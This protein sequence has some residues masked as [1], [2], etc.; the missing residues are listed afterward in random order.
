MGLGDRRVQRSA[1]PDWDA[2]RV[3]PQSVH[4]TSL[5]FFTRLWG[6]SAKFSRQP[7][8]KKP[9]KPQI[10]LFASL[11]SCISVIPF[12]KCVHEDRWQR[13]MKQPACSGSLTHTHTWGRHATSAEF[14]DSI[15]RFL[16]CTCNTNTPRRLPSA[17]GNS[18]VFLVART[19]FAPP[20]VVRKPPAPP[21]TSTHILHR[22]LTCSLLPLKSCFCSRLNTMW[23]LCLVYMGAL[24]KYLICVWGLCRNRP[25]FPPDVRTSSVA[26]MGETGGKH[27]STSISA[28]GRDHNLPKTPFINPLW[29][30]ISISFIHLK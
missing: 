7:P 23:S 30:I 22:K 9:S 17:H 10:A 3:L 2:A 24:E 20:G 12:L 25:W 21:S 26:A 11:R 18:Y 4:I 16:R 28:F 8:E 15:I 5:F 14:Y 29:I 13:E 6:P 19:V 1:R 27:A